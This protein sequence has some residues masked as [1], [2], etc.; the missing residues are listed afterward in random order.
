M[1]KGW[2]WAEPST[3]SHCSPGLSSHKQAEEEKGPLCQ[4][5]LPQWLK[6]DGILWTQPIGTGMLFSCAQLNLKCLHIGNK[7]TKK[8]LAGHPFIQSTT[9]LH[10]YLI[11]ILIILILYSYQ[12]FVRYRT[13]LSRN[14]SKAK[15]KVT[16]GT[17]Q[18]T[19]QAFSFPAPGLQLFSKSYLKHG[20]LKTWLWGCCDK[21]V[22][23]W[24]IISFYK[25]F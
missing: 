25:R 4:K 22:S 13:A 12:D 23:Y 10:C 2:E 18:R 19:L 3:C 1:P 15:A 14:P 21:S 20:Q 11:K 24:S 6:R 9:F 7:D 16:N 8:C 17:M 5:H